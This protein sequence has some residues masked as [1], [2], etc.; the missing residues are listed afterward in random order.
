MSKE[1]LELAARFSYQCPR[2]GRLEINR[3]LF[4]FIRNGTNQDIVERDLQRLLSYGYYQI[5]ASRNNI[6]DPFDKRVVWAYWIGDDKLTEVVTGEDEKS[7]F[8]FHNFTALESIHRT[9]DADPDY[10]KMSAARVKEVAGDKL[11]VFHRPLVQEGNK[12]SW[13]KKSET[14]R[15]DKGFI[16][17][18]VEESWIVYH[19]GIGRRELLE[20]EALSLIEKTEK[21]IKLFN[22]SSEK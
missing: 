12:F 22:Q 11:F 1:G 6:D 18:V 7:I 2:A 21:A 16:E 15:I 19:R 10:C 5:I 14:L 20:E 4:E 17:D 3:L 9:P 8:L 13:P